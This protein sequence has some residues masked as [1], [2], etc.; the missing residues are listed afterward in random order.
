MS[1]PLEQAKAVGDA[2]LYEGYLLYP[3]RATAAKSK[4]RWQWGVLMPP[5][6]TATDL[7]E[8][9]SSRTECVLEARPDSTLRVTARFLQAQERVAQELAG[10]QFVD[11]PS[12]TVGGTEYTTWDEAVEREVDAELRVS[13][14]LAHPVEVPFSVA[15]TE[16]Y[17]RVGSAARLIRRTRPLSGV[18]K[19]SASSLDGPPGGVRLRVDLRNTSDWAEPVPTRKAALHHALLAAHLVLALDPGQFLSLLDPPDWAR[20]AADDCVNT[21]TWPVLIGGTERASAVLSSPIILYDDPEIGA[22]GAGEL[23]GTTEIDEIMPSDLLD[24]LHGTIRYLRSVTDE[25]LSTPANTEVME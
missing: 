22:D 19:M 12:L 17:E 10:Y 24:R 16:R 13:D 4:V 15:G 5:S 11:V 20:T 1:S 23:F 2:V 14:L 8:H 9:A 6:F 7:G 3:Y 18:L 25:P 21:R